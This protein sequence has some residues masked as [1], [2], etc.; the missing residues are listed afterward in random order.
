MKPAADTPFSKSD[1]IQALMI[2]WS[3]RFAVLVLLLGISVL[4]GWWLDVD[5]LKR[6]FPIQWL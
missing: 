4:L 3:V 2:Q 1:T 6:T 5:F